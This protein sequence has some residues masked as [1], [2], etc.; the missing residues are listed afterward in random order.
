MLSNPTT[1][2]ARGSPP[3]PTLMAGGWL[4]VNLTAALLW[5]REMLAHSVEEENKT[6]LQI[7]IVRNT[8]NKAQPRGGRSLKEN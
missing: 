1:T 8:V 3:E 5:V 6:P 2:T 7:N 4:C